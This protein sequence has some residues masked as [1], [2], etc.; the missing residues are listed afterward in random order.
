MNIKYVATAV[1]LAVL[2]GIG[3]TQGERQYDNVSVM[4]NAVAKT[5]CSCVF[6]AGRDLADCRKDDPPGFDLASAWVD[7]EEQAV[8]AS[9]YAV[10]R[11][12]AR[13]DPATGC[14]LE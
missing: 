13:F 12:R 6:V 7:A 1:G 14:T 8:G 2:I 11:G 4:V 10:V 5:A 3:M 9:L